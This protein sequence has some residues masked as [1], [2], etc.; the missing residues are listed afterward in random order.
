M[1]SV[2][3]KMLYFGMAGDIT[4]KREEQ[5]ALDR[6]SVGDLLDELEH[7][8]AR[9]RGLRRFSRVAVDEELVDER[10]V[11]KGGETVALLPPVA[12]G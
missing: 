12:G 8:Y 10:F 5:V 3:V 11:L 6:G 4:G 9:L 2:K 1:S 7:K